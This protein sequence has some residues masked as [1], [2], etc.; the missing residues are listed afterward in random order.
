MCGK[1]DRSDYFTV[2]PP[3]TTS[4]VPVIKSASEEARNTAAPAISS[5]FPALPA[6]VA[7]MS[8]FLA[9]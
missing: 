3:S 8:P 6:G 1:W 2:H 9:S 4:D 7:D 5:G